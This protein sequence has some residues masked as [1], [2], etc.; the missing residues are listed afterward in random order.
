MPTEIDWNLLQS[1]VGRLEVACIK[2]THQKVM[3]QSGMADLSDKWIED[4]GHRAIAEI[5][6]MMGYVLIEDRRTKP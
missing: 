5:A 6:A 3:R 1:P 4:V 2:I